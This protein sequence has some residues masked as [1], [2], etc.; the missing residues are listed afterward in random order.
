MP[1]GDLQDILTFILEVEK[2]KG[3]YRRSKPLG[4]ERYENSAEHSWQVSLL[5]LLCRDQA[6]F[7]V[8]AFKAVKML[9]VHDVVEIDAGDK[10]IYSPEHDDFENESKAAARIFGLLPEALEAEC[11]VLW[12]EYEAKETPEAIYAYAM[13]RAMPLWQ[14]LNNGGV[15]WVENDIVYEQVVDKNAPI[16]NASQELWEILHAKLKRMVTEGALEAGTSLD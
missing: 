7:D 15:T 4:Q 13:D 11:L 3:I 12:H 2:L 6:D 16:G 1:A 5:A 10:M 9:L 14:N 8:D